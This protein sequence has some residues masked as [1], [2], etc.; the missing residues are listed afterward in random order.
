MHKLDAQ[1]T[2]L[3][4]GAFVAGCHFLWA[5]IVALGFGQRLVDFKLGL[6]MISIPVTVGPFNAATAVM[7]IVAAFIAGYVFGWVFAWLWN[8]LHRA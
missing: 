2:A 7:M 8:W 4:L 1:K 3:T 5:V 6:H